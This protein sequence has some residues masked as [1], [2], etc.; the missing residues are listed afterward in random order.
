[1]GFLYT[2]YTVSRFDIFTNRDSNAYVDTKHIYLNIKYKVM[3]AADK[4]GFTKDQYI[5]IAFIRNIA[6][7]LYYCYINLE[8]FKIIYEA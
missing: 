8:M 4:S 5:I 3:N 6:F 1:M 2:N 7:S